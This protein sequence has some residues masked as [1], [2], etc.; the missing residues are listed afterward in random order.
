[1]EKNNAF[2]VKNKGI[3]NEFDNIESAFNYVKQLTK[4]VTIEVLTRKSWL[5]VK[6]NLKD[7]ESENPTYVDCW[8]QCHFGFYE[9]VKVSFLDLWS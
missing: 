8:E 3:D 7:V 2:V 9:G 1:M 4:E 5:S 6:K